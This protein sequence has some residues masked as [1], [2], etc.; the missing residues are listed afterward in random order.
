[1]NSFKDGLPKVLFI[2]DEESILSSIKRLLRKEPY[3]VFTTSSP[4][5]V[6]EWISKYSFS[7]IVSDQRMPLKEG[8]AILAEVRKSSPSTVRL[9]LTGYADMQSA[10]DAINLGH[11]YRFLTKPWV[12]EDLRQIIRQAVEQYQILAENQRLQLLTAKQNE[13]LLALNSDLEGRVVKRTSEVAA[14]NKKLELSFLESI[15]VMGGLAEYSGFLP[16]G[17]AKRVARLS[18]EVAKQMGLPDSERLDIQIAAY[19]HDIGKLGLARDRM[20]EHPVRGAE[21]AK[22]VPGLER[23]SQMILQ[24]HDDPATKKD[25]P[26][27]S[28]ILAVVD[29]YDKHLYVEESSEHSTPSK[30]IQKIREKCPGTFSTEVVDA[31]ARYLAQEGHIDDVEFETELSLHDLRP[32]MITSRPIL[33]R[34]GR[35][36]LSSDYKLDK[37]IL[38]RL[39]KRHLHSPIVNEVFVYRKTTGQGLASNKKTN[40]VSRSKVAA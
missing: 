19:L 32:G 38:S 37:E 31:L 5:Q 8:V 1:M 28:L 22:M 33:F 30:V 12:D 25:I 17:H 6:T 15:K 29:A 40:Q 20:E 3:E 24:H 26:T 7:V 10:L 34:D 36:V 11:I 35:M 9:M 4:E 18:G 21:I 16:K 23:V 14:L 2:D 39:W 27:G 13:E